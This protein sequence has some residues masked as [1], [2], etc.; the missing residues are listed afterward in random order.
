[1][2]NQSSSKSVGAAAPTAPTLTRSLTVKNCVMIS[3]ILTYYSFHL[4]GK[5]TRGSRGG[6]YQSNHGH[7]TSSITSSRS[8]SSSSSTTTS[9]SRP[10][11]TKPNKENNMVVDSSSSQS[12]NMKKSSKSN[13]SSFDTSSAENRLA[14][15]A[16]SQPVEER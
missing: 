8:R 11:S 4:L 9:N 15:S 10:T 13:S 1:M 5:T 7:D 14:E 6:H 12:A 16:S 3:C 2:Q